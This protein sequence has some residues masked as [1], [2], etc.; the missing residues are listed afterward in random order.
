MYPRM[1]FG[2]MASNSRSGWWPY[3]CTYVTCRASCMSLARLG[4]SRMS[5]KRSKRERSAAGSWMFSSGVLFV[6]YREKAGLAAAR[7]DV[8]ALSVVVMPALAIETVC[9]SIT[10]WIAVRS[11]SSILSNSSM[12]QMPMSA[13]TSAPPSR[14]KSPVTVSRTTAAVR[15]TPDEPLPVVYTER[16]A[17]FVTCL[18]S[19]DLAT[20]GSPMRQTLMSPRMRMPSP[21]CRVAPPT[22][23]S[24]SAFFTS[25]WP[26]ISGAMD[27]AIFEYIS[28]SSSRHCSMNSLTSSSAV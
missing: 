14:T 7:T 24:S 11:L 1:S 10:S 13:S 22:M 2:L 27:C 20:P 16:G 25:V 12:Q 4:L 6:L 8:R 19:C 18:R 23:R 21:I 28:S 15:P 9:C 17:R 5:H 3:W 26:K